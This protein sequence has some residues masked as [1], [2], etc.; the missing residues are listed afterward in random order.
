[1]STSIQ[2]Y[3]ARSEPADAWVAW[4]GD[5]SKDYAYGG[6]RLVGWRDRMED[7]VGVLCSLMHTESAYKNVLINE[8][9]RAG[10]V[11]D[12]ATALPPGFR[13]STVGGGRCVIRPADA[14][15]AEILSHPEH[16]EFRSTVHQVFAALGDLL[17]E[18]E[19]RIKLTPDFGKYAGVADLLHE[20]TP[21]VLG[22]HCDAGGCG[23]KSSYSAT[24]VTAAHHVL[25]DEGVI[26]A[27]RTTLIGSAGAM[28]EDVLTY[29]QDQGGELAVCD[30]KYDAG[31]EAA[32][33]DVRLLPSVSGRF[34][35]E[36]LASGGT[37]IAT[38]WGNELEHSNLTALAPGTVLLLAHNLAIPSGAGGKEL[39]AEVARADVLALP[40]QLLTLGGA[41]TSRLE[42]FSRQSGT[43][44]FDKP[45]AHRVVSRVVGDW[46]RR[47]ARP[48]DGH[49][50]AYEA[51]LDVCEAA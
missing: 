42:W 3:R 5:E 47:M 6:C 7:V 19:G 36:A 45:L 2:I 27:P 32:P 33:D 17:N 43:T 10:A 34:T 20:H 26:D 44:V 23:G 14:R 4:D 48:A 46:T 29:L 30:L 51:L 41:L 12:L 28:G 25:A 37:V 18:R 24:G 16:P 31:H 8:A 21:H 1:M 40:G 9:L 39:M 22:V 11:D 13:D 50:N 15:Y 35:D 38:T 49:G